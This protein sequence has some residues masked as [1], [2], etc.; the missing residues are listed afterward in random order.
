MNSLPPHQ[1]LKTDLVVL[2]QKGN[3]TPI[4]FVISLGIT[5]HVGLLSRH[6]HHNAG[7]SLPCIGFENFRLSSIV[8]KDNFSCRR[9]CSRFV[10]HTTLF[11]KAFSCRLYFVQPHLD[12]MGSYQA[13]QTIDLHHSLLVL[14]TFVSLWAERFIRIAFWLPIIELLPY[15]TSCAIYSR[16]RLNG[17]FVTTISD[18]AARRTQGCEN[19]L[20]AHKRRPLCCFCSSLRSAISARLKEPSL[21]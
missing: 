18:W 6:S 15:S 7:N 14:A 3:R 5:L 9:P 10:N 20:I 1:K 4:T 17:G 12:W 8:I 2:M 11:T 16:N 13:L 21:L 19:R